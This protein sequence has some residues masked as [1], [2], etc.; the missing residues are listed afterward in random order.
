MSACYCKKRFVLPAAA[1]VK[2]LW[3]HIKLSKWGQ[4]SHRALED[5][6]LYRLIYLLEFL[7]VFTSVIL[8]IYRVGS[9]T[10]SMAGEK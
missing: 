8:V 5:N 1:R 10:G 2:S 6:Y 3:K 7:L 9:S 4:D